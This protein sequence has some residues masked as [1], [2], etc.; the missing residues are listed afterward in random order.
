M[1]AAADTFHR[2]LAL[3]LGGAGRDVDVH[4]EVAELVRRVHARLVEP[5]P[6]TRNTHGHG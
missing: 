5:F 1:I 2:F 6:I 3:E 4:H